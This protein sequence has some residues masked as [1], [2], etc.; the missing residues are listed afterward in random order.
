MYSIQT[1]PEITRPIIA[2]INV[3]AKSAS[4][5]PAWWPAPLPSPVS[6]PSSSSS[7]ERL[8]VG[9]RAGNTRKRLRRKGG[10]YE[11]H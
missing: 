9:A 11:M 3:D 5:N 6:I 7:S 2:I 10:G 4:W 1:I 8:S